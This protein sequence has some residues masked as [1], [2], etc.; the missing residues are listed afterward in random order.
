M[1][2]SLH[3]REKFA[4]IGP[5]CCKRTSVSILAVTWN[6]GE[7]RPPISSPFFRW[8]KENCVDKSIVV[9]SLQE[10]E[11]GGTS[12]ALAA[13]RETLASKSQERGNA[14]AQF[15]VNAIASGL[16]DRAWYNVSLRQLSGMLI[17]V[18]AKRDLMCN[19]GDIHTSSVACGILGVGGNKG[20][21][22][23]QLTLHRHRF[24]FI[25]SHFAAHQNAVDIRNAN[26]HTIVKLLNFKN[27]PSIFDEDLPEGEG[28]IIESKGLLGYVEKPA[29]AATSDE[30]TKTPDAQLVAPE[31]ASPVRESPDT[32]ESL[33]NMDAVIWMG[34]LNYRIDGNYEQ[35]CQLIA[36][37]DLAPLLACDQLRREHMQSRVFRGYREPEITFAPT[38]KFDKGIT[39]ALSYDSSEKRRVPAW[40]DRIM[41]RGSAPFT[42]PLPSQA[43]Q[44]GKGLPSENKIDVSPIEYGSWMDVCDS[45]H[46]PVYATFD[47]ALTVVDAS[48]K[49][50]IVSQILLEGQ[51]NMQST[52]KYH[53]S[54]STVRLHAFHMPDQM[55]TLHNK[56]SKPLCF[57][58]IPTDTLDLSV[59]EL[60]PAN[61]RVLPNESR[62]IF[63]KA[64][65]ARHPSSGKN[66]RIVK[67]LL[68]VEYEHAIGG[69]TALHTKTDELTAI[70][71]PEAS[72]E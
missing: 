64:N 50:D 13:A 46:K 28:E 39:G 32:L 9:V 68:R 45:D 20:A 36:S 61:G 57:S 11:M 47:V 15:W 71:L 54:P 22:G 65:P 3:C 51:Q 19:L 30:S 49:R 48:K 70:L 41:Y 23:V 72:P 35:V 42:S 7:S 17:A 4:K 44:E 24:A 26:Y 21:V 66:A 18:F 55:I 43:D 67:Y 40:C 31:A 12:V 34:D 58:C 69:L 59:V 14:N 16:G 60:R 33:R 2:F 10:V 5:Q 25:C 63:L 6:V 37:R 56:D 29:V 62:E 8:I 38:Y 52:P 53:I 1:E 27:T